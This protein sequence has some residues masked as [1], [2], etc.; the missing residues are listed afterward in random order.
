MQSES[1]S[2]PI[3]MDYSATTPVDPRVVEKMIPY[4]YERSAIPASRSHCYG[5]EAEEAVEKARRH[6]ADLLHADPREIIWTWGATEGNNLAIKGAANFYKSAGRHIVTAKTEHKAV[7]DTCRELER[8]GFEV[9]YLD[10]G[11]DGLLDLTTVGAALTRRHGPR[12][13]HD[14]QQRDRCDTTDHRGRRDVP[15][16]RHRVSL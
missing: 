16:E 2:R 4:L 5:W 12:V 11:Q 15:R 6:V 7:L 8:Q 3:Y 1:S 13:R 9:T 10:V 14:G